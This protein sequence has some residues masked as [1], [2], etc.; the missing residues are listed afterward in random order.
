MAS[1]NQQ[2]GGGVAQRLAN[3][4]YIIDPDIPQHVGASR[5]RQILAMV[6]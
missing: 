1:A 2:I 6:L 5:L 3:G 4:D